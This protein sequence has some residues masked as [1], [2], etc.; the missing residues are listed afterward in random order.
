MEMVPLDLLVKLASFGT[1]GVCVLAI[2]LVGKSI[3]G[4]PDNSPPWRV[5][6]LHK[7]QYFCVLM[8]TV[9]AVSGVANAYF[10]QQKIV[11]AQDNVSKLAG[12][13][14]TESKG[15]RANK[16]ELEANINSINT[17]IARS[18]AS[19]EVRES[20]SKLKASIGRIRIRP[21]EELTREM[22]INPVERRP[23]RR[24]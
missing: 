1:A 14:K 21:V 19:P 15:W 9:S 4:L 3:L 11:T 22:G 20:V 10:N 8:A 16:E 18:N 23:V 17:S 2:F 12:L 5:S 13:Y 7:Y 6:L 24:P